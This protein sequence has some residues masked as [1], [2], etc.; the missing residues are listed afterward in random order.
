MS[1]AAAISDDPSEDSSFA[2]D[3][4]SNNVYICRVLKNTQAL[5]SWATGGVSGRFTTNV[6]RKPC[7]HGCL[8]C[9]NNKKNPRL[10]GA[11]YFLC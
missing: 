8:L 6:L 4:F 5:S 10:S 2:V 1:S 11:G 7:C 3:N 9:F